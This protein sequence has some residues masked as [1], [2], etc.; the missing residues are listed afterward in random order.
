MLDK[1]NEMV[2]EKVENVK[3]M[4]HDKMGEVSE[5]ISGTINEHLSDATQKATD[6]SGGSGGFTLNYK[7]YCKIFIFI[8]IVTD[9][10]IMLNRCAALIQANVQ[11]APKIG[12][13]DRAKPNFDITKAYTMMHVSSDVKIRTLFS[14]G[15]QT[16]FNEATGENDMGFS[17]GNMTMDSVTMKYDHVNGY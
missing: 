14:W 17:L 15:A 8:H 4:F 6:A 3:G 12:E 5:K 9:E 2:D 11:N 10:N 7:E 13:D 16:T 1:L